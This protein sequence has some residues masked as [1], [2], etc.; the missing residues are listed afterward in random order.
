MTAIATQE[1]FVLVGSAG[2]IGGAIARR[3]AVANPCAPIWLTY[4]A[5]LESAE[6]TRD[7]IG[8]GEV[9]K[10]DAT[11][12]DALAG[13]ADRLL[14]A[15]QRVR[16]M[17]HG[18]VAASPGGI[19]GNSD[20]LLRHLDVSAVSLARTVSALRGLLFEGSSV[21]YLSSDGGS[22]VA[23]DY[24]HIGV[25]KAAG[26]A[27]VRYLALELGKLG[28]RINSIASGPVATKAFAAVVDDPERWEAAARKRSLIQPGADVDDLAEFVVA[29]A[30]GA[31][32][33]VTGQYLRVDGGLGLRL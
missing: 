23:E 27:I 20:D 33:G 19:L 18:V 1:A 11:D 32:R 6:Q 30:G 7:G 4:A 16:V 13:L 25:A 15:G 3:Y 12:E 29:M 28:V 26:D 10:C 8:R 24:G 5:D 9:V 21:F 17:V 2:G 31:G 22:K 14:F